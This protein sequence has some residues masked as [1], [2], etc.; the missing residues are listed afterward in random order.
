MKIKS[1]LATMLVATTAL[2]S[3][4]ANASTK[5]PATAYSDYYTLSAQQ[6]AKAQANSQT[7]TLE[8]D[9]QQ[10]VTQ[11]TSNAGRT[12]VVFGNKA[13]ATTTYNVGGVTINTP[14]T[15]SIT[16]INAGLK[17]LNINHQISEISYFM[18]KAEMMKKS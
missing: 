12:L 17:A 16:T 14:T 11:V 18:T 5:D 8:L 2:V 15:M 3:L 13:Q 9:G 4:N 10:V 1:I 6:K 7:K